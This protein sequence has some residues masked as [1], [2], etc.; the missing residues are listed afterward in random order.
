MKNLTASI[1]T[2]IARAINIH[3]SYN[4]SEISYLFEADLTFKQYDAVIPF[5]QWCHDNN[6]MFG[7][8]NYQERYQEYLNK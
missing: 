7:K 4:P 6:K 5:L 8:G 3:G 1:Y 2:L